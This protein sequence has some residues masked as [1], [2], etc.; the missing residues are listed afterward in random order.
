MGIKNLLAVTSTAL[1]ISLSVYANDTSFTA[2]LNSE[3]TKVNEPV[4]LTITFTGNGTPEEPD[5]PYNDN[6]EI[7]LAGTG[8]QIQIINGVVTNSQSYNY[9]VV[10]KKNG[11]FTIKDIST[12]V[13]GKKVF[14][15]PIQLEVSDEEKVIKKEKDTKIIYSTSEVN[16]KEVYESEPFIYTLKLYRSV[17]TGNYS[18]KYPEFKDF[19]VD[20]FEKG[21][22][23]YETVN[24]KKYIVT[25]VKKALSSSKTGL[26]KIDAGMFNVEVYYDV[27]DSQFGGFFSQRE[28]KIEDFYSNTLQVKVKELPYV[29]PNNFSGVVG[30]EIDAES[31]ISQD[32]AEVGDSID[33]TVIFTGKANLND[34]K[35]EL[36]NIDGFKIYSDKPI[37]RTF[38]DGKDLIFDRRFKFAL[39]PTKG[40]KL[41]IPAMKI[42]YFNITKKRYDF[43]KTKKTIINV[44][45]NAENIKTEETKSDNKITEKSNNLNT[46]NPIKTENNNLDIFTDKDIFD[47]KSLTNNN[48]L[49]YLIL[50]ML[51]GLVTF[52]FK[53]KD[54]VLKNKTNSNNYEN[55][56]NSL[57][58]E[59]SLEKLINIFYD[60]LNI[61]F[62]ITKNSNLKQEL[63]KL[64][65]SDI[66]VKSIIDLIE[67]YDYI[68]FSGGSEKKESKQEIFNL[69]KE[70][71]NI[72]EKL[73]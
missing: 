7:R 19:W 23:F 50:F 38:F 8:S 34:F 11:K 62:S 16:K 14:A 45:G 6:F 54:K 21:K 46:N 22:E 58:S 1:L 33:L 4:E 49:I 66:Q 36:P 39:V 27:D 26:R 57:N 41:E 47:N 15:S 73:K 55:I 53:F 35:F 68:K 9:L 12:V 56:I 18:V 32:S 28:T 61:K 64:N 44:S 2:K 31:R 67:K 5:I 3:K 24:G 20:D 69:V 48:L 63:S 30:K 60:Y 42:P 13:D 51:S 29:K 52:L 37:D 17:Q 65:L 25:E 72:L 10:P 43:I 70:N 40:G 71:I 59:M